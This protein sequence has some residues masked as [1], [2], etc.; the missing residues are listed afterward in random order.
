MKLIYA[1]L[2]SMALHLAILYT[3]LLQTL[4][5]IEA[6]N[7]REWLA[8]VYI[9]APVIAI[10]EVLKAMERAMFLLKTDVHSTSL[11]EHAKGHGLGN[12]HVANGKVKAQ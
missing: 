10:D 4:F 11:A 5:S 3:P 7:T 1:I 2:L 6:L 12:G 9:S 8:V